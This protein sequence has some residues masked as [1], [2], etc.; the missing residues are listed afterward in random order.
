MLL[1]DFLCFRNCPR[2]DHALYA[3]SVIGRNEGNFKYEKE[4]L[5][6]ACAKYTLTV[7]L[8][9]TRLSQ[10]VAC[11]SAARAGESLHLNSDRQGVRMTSA[12]RG[13]R[14][15]L[16]GLRR[17]RRSHPELRLQGNS[18]STRKP[19][20]TGRSFSQENRRSTLLH[21]ILRLR[22]LLAAEEAH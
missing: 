4:L 11:S 14:R 13:C 19:S 16:G 21:F 22:S 18:T 5:P 7:Q 12:L 1:N 8:Q 10:P 9:H 17:P 20:D 3:V 6:F 2:L 15:L